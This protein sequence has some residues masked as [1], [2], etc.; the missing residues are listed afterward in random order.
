MVWAEIELFGIKPYGYIY[1]HYFLEL[2]LRV[3]NILIWKSRILFSPHSCEW[4][5]VW[6]KFL[7]YCHLLRTH[8]VASCIILTFI[9]NFGIKIEWW[10]F[11]LCISEMTRFDGV[12]KSLNWVGQRGQRLRSLHKLIARQPTCKLNYHRSLQGLP[13]KPSAAN[14]KDIQGKKSNPIAT[15]N[16][17]LDQTLQG[18]QSTQLKSKRIIK[19]SPPLTALEFEDDLGADNSEVMV[20]QLVTTGNITREDE[21]SSYMADRFSFSS[22][23]WSSSQ[24]V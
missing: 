24:L 11:V 10:I 23:R 7:P 9:V 17:N 2:I 6:L 14:A 4:C 22:H 15:A 12:W 20:I 13:R 1:P 19:L 16:C 18:Q 8:V 21:N 5:G 3:E